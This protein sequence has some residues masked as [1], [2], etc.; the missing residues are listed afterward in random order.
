MTHLHQIVKR[1]LLVLGIG[2]A[3][4]GGVLVTHGVAYHCYSPITS[5]VLSPN[6][7]MSVFPSIGTNVDQLVDQMLMGVQNQVAPVAQARVSFILARY[8]CEGKQCQITRLNV[9]IHANRSTE[10]T[11]PLARDPD[12]AGFDATT[13]YIFD[14]SEGVVKASSEPRVYLPNDDNSW[15]QSSVKVE[16]ASEIASSE[17]SAMFGGARYELSLALHKEGW[18]VNY[19]RDED[20]QF[21]LGFWI[22]LRTG[23]KR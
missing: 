18:K 6:P 17:L 23:E 11:A 20:V 8:L 22:D 5:F 4:I 2:L 9:D 12:E 21:A 13:T 19:R 3:A 7:I 10:C 1:A 14:F 15:T 16:Q